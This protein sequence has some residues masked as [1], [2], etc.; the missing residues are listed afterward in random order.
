MNTLRSRLWERFYRENKFEPG[1]LCSRG[2]YHEGDKYTLRDAKTGGCLYCMNEIAHYQNG[3]DINAVPEEYYHPY[4]LNLIQKVE[5]PDNPT[6]CWLWHEETEKSPK[7]S[8]IYPTL[9]SKT[10]LAAKVI[11]YFFRGDIGNMR[12][13]KLCMNPRCVNP[14]HYTPV[15]LTGQ[16]VQKRFKNFNLDWDMDEFINYK[17]NREPAQLF[18]LCDYSLTNS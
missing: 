1:V 3:F 12:L 11:F 18:E 5:I 7:T 16:R 17:Y 10:V 14:L 6:D 2:H 8:F 4:F 9:K 15:K 13:K